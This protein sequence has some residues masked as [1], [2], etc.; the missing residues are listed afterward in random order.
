[1]RFKRR[2]RTP[3]LITDRKRAAALRWQQRQRD[4]VP[5]LAE[6][7]EEQQPSI[8]HVMHERVRLW[9]STEQSDRDW[10]AR[11]WRHA[12]RLLDA[13]EPTIRRALLDY[14]N[15]HRWLPSDP[16][17]LLGTI[18]RFATGRLIIV[19]GMIQPARVTIPVAEAADIEAKPK[20][21]TPRWLSRLN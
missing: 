2:P 10:R 6:L 21:F 4:A 12:R 16:T 8:D 3:Y 14:W 11:Q 20:P 5:L 13:H 19:D 15:G 9:T 1:M 18:N 7:V 17:Y